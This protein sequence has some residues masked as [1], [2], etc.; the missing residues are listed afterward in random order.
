M[1]L[2]EIW[3]RLRVASPDCLTLCSRGPGSPT[4]T[5]PR[6]ARYYPGTFCKLANF[7]SGVQPLNKTCLA[8]PTRSENQMGYGAAIQNKTKRNAKFL[9]IAILGLVEE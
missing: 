3:F 1:R 4:R 9:T 5:G 7:K 8:P 6:D 2:R